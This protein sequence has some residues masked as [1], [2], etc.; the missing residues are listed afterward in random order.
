L[1]SLLG[2]LKSWNNLISINYSLDQKNISIS[3]FCNFQIVPFLSIIIIFIIIIIMIIFR[4]LRVM[5]QFDFSKFLIR[6]EEYLKINPAILK[7]MTTIFQVLFISH[8]ICCLW[9]GLCST[10][11]RVAWFDIQTQVYNTLGN[12]FLILYSYVDISIIIIRHHFYHYH[13]HHHL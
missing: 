7:L 11:D 5:K 9:F 6:S 12:A 2:Y 10:F 3:I 1:S 13:Y 4:L 8:M